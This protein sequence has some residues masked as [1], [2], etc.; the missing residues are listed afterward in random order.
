MKTAESKN[1]IK[2]IGHNIK[3]INYISINYFPFLFYVSNKFSIG[4][5]GL[6]GFFLMSVKSLHYPLPLKLA[7]NMLFI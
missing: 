7:E 5:L 3:K 2:N 6:F 4:I 1:N